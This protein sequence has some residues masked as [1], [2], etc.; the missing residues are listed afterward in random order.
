MA[1]AFGCDAPGPKA[2]AKAGAPNLVLITLDTTRADRLG[3]YG[4]ARGTTPVLDALAAR[5]VRFGDAV[6]QATTTPPSHAS[7]L[8]GLDPPRHGLRKLYG[9]RL[10]D[11][12]LT[13]AEV[14]QREGYTTAA[15]VSAVPL[16]HGVGLDQGFDVYD[17]TWEK[18]SPDHPSHNGMAGGTNERVQAWLAEKPEAPV[19]LWVHYFDPHFPYFAPESFRERFG[20]G[21]VKRENLPLPTDTNREPAPGKTVWH[22]KPRMVERM[23]SLYDAEI[24]YMDAAVGELL[25]S[26]R[27]AGLLE[28]SVIAVVADHGEQL[29]EGGYYFGHWDVLDQTAHVPMLLVAS[30]GRYAGRVVPDTVGSV[31]LMPTVLAWLGVEAPPGLDGIDLSPLLAGEKVAPRTYYTEQ[32]D[33]FPVRAVRD[34]DWMLRQGAHRLQRIEDG[35]I[36]LA[37][38]TAPAPSEAA[39]PGPETQ[40]RL[41]RALDAFASPADAHPSETLGLSDEVRA[42]LQ[43]LGYSD[44]GDDAAPEP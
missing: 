12:N 41:Q 17:D 20:V 1:P 42:E 29:G 7:I 30:D 15:F 39:P 36:R 26:L 14:L 6:A 25:D 16:R 19:F 9:Q 2:T 33:F 28:N 5:G 37:P 24:A 44:E 35:T 31:D 22:P 21:S 40:S 11:E 3:C 4:Y 10:S 27:A 23:S 18:R 32:L 13:L 43:A 8:T 38:R 34:G